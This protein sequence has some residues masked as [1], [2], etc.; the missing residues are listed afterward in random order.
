VS[1]RLVPAAVVY[2]AEPAGLTPDLAF[3]RAL[4]RTQ[5]NLRRGRRQQAR[6][7][8]AFALAALAAWTREETRATAAL[9]TAYEVAESTALALR[10]RPSRTAKVAA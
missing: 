6:A 10:Q 9:V 3:T 7:D 2:T 4:R 5:E 1:V 8:F